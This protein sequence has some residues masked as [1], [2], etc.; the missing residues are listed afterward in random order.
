MGDVKVID[1]LA[2]LYVKDRKVLFVRSHGKNI[3]YTVGGKREVGETDKEALTRESKEELG[4]DLIPESI[5][6][7]NTF[8][9]NADSKEN[10]SIKLTCYEANFLDVPSPNSEI[11]EMCWFDTRDIDKTTPTGKQVLFWLKEKNLIN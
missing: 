8:E 4:I 11:E 3:F 9:D 7:L 2:L 10:I 6:Y 1:K 5:K